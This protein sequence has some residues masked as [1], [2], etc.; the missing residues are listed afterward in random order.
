[1]T[2]RV[3]RYIGSWHVAE[4]TCSR[5]GSPQFLSNANQAKYWMLRVKCNDDVVVLI[6]KLGPMSILREY[7]RYSPTPKVKGWRYR[8]IRTSTY[9]QVTTGSVV[10]LQQW[11]PVTGA[12]R[13]QERDR[14][15]A[16]LCNRAYKG[17]SRAWR[18]DRGIL[19]SPTST[20][21]LSRPFLFNPYRPGLRVQDNGKRENGETAA[22]HFASDANQVRSRSLDAEPPS[23]SDEPVP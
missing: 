2:G 3:R 7:L 8:E 1:M 19:C 6:T 5:S 21:L 4:H 17:N 14:W 22:K 16:R 23:T 13:Q 18:A 9:S 20:P 15:K 10:T 11:K 12:H